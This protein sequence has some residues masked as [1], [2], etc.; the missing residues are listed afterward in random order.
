M[1]PSFIS[2]A[3]FLS[4]DCATDGLVSFGNGSNGP[5][6]TD[7]TGV[8]TFPFNPPGNDARRSCEKQVQE[9]PVVSAAGF[10]QRQP[11]NL[12]GNGSNLNEKDSVYSDL[13]REPAPAEM[14][15]TN[16]GPPTTSNNRI[17]PM[18][19]EVAEW[20]ILWEGLQVGERIGIGK[21]SFL[22][23]FSFM[24]DII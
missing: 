7:A 9:S 4:S 21:V 18:L 19:G 12:V 11:E 24:E 14:Q 16:H 3:S 22:H 2:S 17:H 15:I 5:V 23:L 8:N 1:K 20:E 6:P 10:C 13:G